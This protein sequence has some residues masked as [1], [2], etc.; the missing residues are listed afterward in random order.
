MRIAP[1]I[2]WLISLFSLAAVSAGCGCSGNTGTVK[3][4]DAAPQVD[5]A[6]GDSRV[7]DASFSDGGDAGQS[8]DG[9]VITHDCDHP[10]FKLPMDSGRKLKS[11]P[12]GFGSFFFL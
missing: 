12:S 2:V 10:F 5:A 9:S 11:S 7:D 4:A 3:D 6:V 8:L 1:I